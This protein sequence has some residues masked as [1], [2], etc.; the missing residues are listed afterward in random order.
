M[1][2]ASKAQQAWG[3]TATGKKALGQA[4]VNK[5]DKL[6]KGAKLPARKGRPGGRSS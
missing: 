2:W 6:S 5:R 3:H 4:D 1:K